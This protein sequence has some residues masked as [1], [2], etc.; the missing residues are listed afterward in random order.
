MLLYA[1]FLADGVIVPH[2]TNTVD[3]PGCCHTHICLEMR[4]SYYMVRYS[5]FIPG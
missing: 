5:I 2:G 1:R 4:L 3:I